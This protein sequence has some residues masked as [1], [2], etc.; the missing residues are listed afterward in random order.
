MKAGEVVYIRVP[1]EDVMTC[2][3]LVRQAGI[4]TEGMSLASCIR[5]ALS[6]LCQ[7]ARDAGTA[8]VRDG[9]EYMDMIGP[10]LQGTGAQ[11]RK[12]AV[13]AQTSGQ[14]KRFNIPRARQHNEPVP[15]PRAQRQARLSP[16]DSARL[17]QLNELWY[18]AVMEGKAKDE[19]D[20]ASANP[21]LGKE[22]FTLR[23]KAG[24]A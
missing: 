15:S 12:L 9:F 14:P 2:V 16:E 18:R 19:E 11:R 23:I 4:Y 13:A 20:W 21:D 8:P 17:D 22:L 3:D 5:L 10:F 24:D 7:G 1:P 6:G